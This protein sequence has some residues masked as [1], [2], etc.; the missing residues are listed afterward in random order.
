MI[1]IRPKALLEES[2]FT[3]GIFDRILGIF[4]QKYWTHHMEK[5]QNDVSNFFIVLL[6]G[7]DS[8]SALVVFR[9]HMECSPT[10]H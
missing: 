8:I 6:V 10:K 1:G 9:E 4:T 5:L 2:T 3:V 7:A